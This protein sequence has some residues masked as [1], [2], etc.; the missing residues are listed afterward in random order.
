MS[1]GIKLAAAAVGTVGLN[2]L[3][4]YAYIANGIVAGSLVGIN[5]AAARS[6]STQALLFLLGAIGTT[7]I[8]SVLIVL[9]AMPREETLLSGLTSYWPFIVLAAIVISIVSIVGV[10]FGISAIRFI[11]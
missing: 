2:T 7:V 4:I 10:D 3:L 9:T 1:K 5:D 6:H 8:G 11:W